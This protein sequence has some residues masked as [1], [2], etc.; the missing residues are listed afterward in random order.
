M[1][2]FINC[3]TEAHENPIV[4]CTS[5]WKLVYTSSAKLRLVSKK[6]SAIMPVTFIA[7]AT[8]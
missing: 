6:S 1:K 8:I 3:P 5:S 2:F 4:E 7:T